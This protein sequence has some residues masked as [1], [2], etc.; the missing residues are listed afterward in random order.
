MSSTQSST[1]RVRD[2]RIIDADNHM[3]EPYDLWTSRVSTQVWGDLVPHVVCNEARQVDL[4]VSGDQVLHAGAATAWAGY[5]QPPPDLPKRWIDIKPEV[6]RADERLEVM[7]RYGIHAAVLYPMDVGGYGGAKFA[8]IAAKHDELALELVRAYNDFVVDFCSV[9]PERYVGLMLV[10]SW[11]ADLAV[12]EMERSAGRGHRGLLFSD[13]PEK[14]GCPTLGDRHWDRLWAA[15]QEMRLPVHFHLGS[16]GYDMGLLPEDAG[17]HVGMAADSA[18]IFLTNTRSM[19]A[20]IG[21]GACH[22][23]PDLKIVLAECGVG[24]I[25]SFLQ[26][27]D[28]MWK[29]TQ[30]SREHPEYDLLPTEYFKRQ[31]YSGFCFEDGVPLDAALEYVGDDHILYETVFPKSSAMVPGPGGHGSSAEDFVTGRLGHLSESTLRRILH[32]NAA[33]LYDIH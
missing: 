17:R 6:W 12:A 8:N 15:A 10:P 1:H 22:R 11:D 21:G 9:G 18:Q 31:I 23:F 19:A 26:A 32:D 5:D 7:N 33:A 24:W 3:V 25:P 16:G 4:W 27:Y 2:I 20:M 14:F 30:V 13:Q 28:W 29:R